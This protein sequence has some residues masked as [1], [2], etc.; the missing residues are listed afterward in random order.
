MSKSGYLKEENLK[1]LL[2]FLETGN[3]NT[4]AN[5]FVI[6]CPAFRES[7]VKTTETLYFEMNNGEDKF[8]GN[9]KHTKDIYANRELIIGLIDRLK[10]GFKSG[11]SKTI[12]SM[13]TKEFKSYLFTC[14]DEYF[15]K[16]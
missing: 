6:G 7:V 2:S 8:I 13:T 12:G 11:K 14:F 3:I 5:I 15:K 4:S 1:R 9:I 10:N 16:R